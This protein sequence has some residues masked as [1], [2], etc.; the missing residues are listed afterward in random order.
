MH[1]YHFA[2]I[3]V[4][5]NKLTSMSNVPGGVPVAMLEKHQ[6]VCLKVIGQS[7]SRHRSYKRDINTMAVVYLLIQGNCFSISIFKVIYWNHQV[8]YSISLHTFVRGSVEHCYIP[9]SCTS[10]FEGR[11]CITGDRWFS[12]LV[13]QSTEYDQRV[14]ASQVTRKMATDINWSWRFYVAYF[15]VAL[16]ILIG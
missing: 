10:G 16:V 13:T 1:T 9:R 8:N 3:H 14:Q 15:L 11:A 4:I 12:I 2:D 6:F 5:L 7:G